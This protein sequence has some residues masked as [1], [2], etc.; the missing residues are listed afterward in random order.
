MP[1]DGS[2]FRAQDP[3]L[4]RLTQARGRL[5]D[6]TN[7][8]AGKYFEEDSR[9]YHYCILGALSADP[10]RDGCMAQDAVGQETA[11]WLARHI[12][13]AEMSFVHASRIIYN[14]N[15][16]YGALEAVSHSAAGLLFFARRRHVNGHKRVL[17]VL[18]GAIA[19][20][21]RELGVVPPAA[22]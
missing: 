15:D 5:A 16:G 14:F 19:A 11:V 9:G 22:V 1:Y 2:A 10:E 21:E 12:S 13:G 18:D 20:R 4:G 8:I 7:W 6:R 3:I 17:D